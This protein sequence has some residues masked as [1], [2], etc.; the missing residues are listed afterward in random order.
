MFFVC[1]EANGLAADEESS[2][3]WLPNFQGKSNV[4]ERQ[5]KSTK[6]E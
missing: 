1:F 6:D 3:V 5:K 4:A 2:N